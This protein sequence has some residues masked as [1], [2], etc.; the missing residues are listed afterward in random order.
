MDVQRRAIAKPVA[1]VSHKKRPFGSDIAGSSARASEERSSVAPP[2]GT[3]RGR[4]YEGIEKVS[5]D[6]SSICE[7]EDLPAVW[8]AESIKTRSFLTLHS[9]I[10]ILNPYTGRRVPSPSGHQGT[11]P[12]HTQINTGRRLGKGHER[13]KTCATTVS[14]ARISLPRRLSRQ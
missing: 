12:R 2:R 13:S 4:E 7:L 11:H 3:K 5:C 6:S 10:N 1:S 9:V 14:N 8:S